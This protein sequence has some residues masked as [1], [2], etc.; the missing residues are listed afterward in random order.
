ISIL[1]ILLPILLYR[2]KEKLSSVKV[3]VV[4]WN[5]VLLLSL[6]S[7]IF[8][9][10][11]TYY[12]FFVD[13]TDSFS[14]NKIS[15]RWIKR[16]YNV[17]KQSLRDNIDY[18]SRI[19]PEKRRVTIIGDSFTAGHGVE[20][21]DDRFGNRLR[22][23]YPN[24]EVHIIAANGSSSGSQLITLNKLIKQDYQ[25]D[26]VLLAYCLNDIDYF[27]PR[28]KKNY[29]EIQ[30]FNKNLSFI[31]RNSY[32]IN[33]FSFR[34]F[35]LMNPKMQGYTNFVLD[36]YKDQIWENQ[37][38]ALRKMI[39]LVKG[40]NA[41]MM[42]V[43]FPFLQTEIENYSFLPVHHKL[44]AFWKDQRILHIDLLET[45]RPY[46]GEELTVNKYDAHPNEFA[47][48]LAADAISNYFK[49]K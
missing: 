16:H 36:A 4:S 27:I 29:S 39:D 15:Q 12:R 23:M 46:L 9:S 10:G 13:T 2:L 11:E 49:P 34:L 37:K 48:Q 14:I 20:K 33:F 38:L 24:M 44:Q 35:A 26:I 45:Y 32:F 21:V 1:F 7:I 41:V 19:Y 6:L 3:Y 25:F 22:K 5:L 28:G 43:T 8:I 30:A 31:E 18:N 17:N 40:Q 42:V 47:H